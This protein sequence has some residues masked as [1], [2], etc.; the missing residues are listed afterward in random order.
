MKQSWNVRRGLV[1]A[2]AAVMMTTA[3]L[4]TMGGAGAPIAQNL[5]FETCKNVAYYGT[6]SATDPQGDGVEFQLVE[7]PARGKV[8]LANDGSGRFVYT[9][10]EDKTGK[11]S[12]RFVAV[13]SQGNSSKP[14]KVTLRIRK[15]KTKVNYADMEGQE[16]WNAAI[17]LAEREVMV[18]EKIGGAYYF[19][20]DEPVS[21]GE[22]LTM[23]MAA[24]GVEPIAQT[25]STGFGDDSAIPDW[26][27][28]YVAAALRAGY[29]LGT[30]DASGQIVFAPEDNVT[31]AEAAVILNRMLEVTDVVVTT[32]YPDT[33]AA[34]AW[35]FQAAVNLESV[36][37]MAPGGGALALEETV[38]RGACARMLAGAMALAE[39]R[40]ESR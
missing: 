18:G 7:K 34:P 29:V 11:D 24:L 22:F 16:S 31:Y 4:A 28:G 19:H 37:V 30:T 2:L 13:D 32:F 10:Y 40:E 38:D 33:V 5:E 12:F 14:A 20:P 27:K 8:E 21:R 1:A 25:M 39:S 36:G 9:P 23:A 17:Y 15:V 6:L 26:S 35:G 3:A